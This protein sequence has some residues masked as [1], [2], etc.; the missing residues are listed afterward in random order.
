M[1]TNLICVAV[2]TMTAANLVFASDWKRFRGPNGSGVSDEKNLPISWGD[3]DSWIDSEN[4]K[5]KIPLPGV[6]SSFPIV[7]GDRVFVTCY[8]GYGLD[9]K[10]PGDIKDL[11]RHLLC[12]DAKSGKIIWQKD[13]EAVLPEDQYRGYIREH[14]YA[15]NTP[16]SDGERVYVFFGKTGVL[17]YDMDGA[18]LWQVSVGSGSSNRR[19]GSAASPILYKNLVIVNASEESRSIIALDKT[20]GK[21]IWKAE[22]N[23][24]ELSYT[25][26]V[27]VPLDKGQQ[28]L[29][30]SMPREVWGLNPDTGKTNWYA[31]INLSGNISPSPMTANG[32]VYVFGGYPSIG[33]VAI[34]TGGKGDVTDSHVMWSTADASYITTPVIFGEHLYWVSDK[35]Y[36][37]CM[38]ADTAEVIFREKLEISGGG[39]PFYASV[40]LADGKIYAVSRKNGTFVFA[41]K[42]QFQQLAH[43]QLASDDSDFNASPAI[44]NG[45][46]FLR[47]NTYLYCIE[48]MSQE[49]PAVK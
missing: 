29:V 35:G 26:P 47:S 40:V 7:V 27:I 25:T 17:A 43:N 28:E 24:L 6:G 32:I 10:S 9:S 8:S 14:G 37:Y 19:W 4:L 12:L 33:G 1:K 3:S 34:R 21:E 5:W 41:A 36:A 20:T 39:N 31:G 2:I 48:S 15:S 23:K 44:S 38:E 45:R 30:I 46:I 42:P 18:K 13:V 49:K 22:S 16:V 11:K